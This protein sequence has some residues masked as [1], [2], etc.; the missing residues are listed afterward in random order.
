MA[1]RKDLPKTEARTGIVTK[2]AAV[3]K[4]FGVKP[5][6]ARGW[7][8]DG[9]PGTPGEYDLAEIEVWKRGRTRDPER[10]AG[11]FTAAA[12]S[13]DLDINDLYNKGM[14]A[15]AE[16]KIAKARIAKAS[17]EKKER[18]NRVASGQVA[19]RDEVERLFSET[20]GRLRDELGRVPLDMQASFPAK[21]RRELTEALTAR[22]NMA[23]TNFAAWGKAIG[24]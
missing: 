12:G 20:L 7:V 14:I 16:E 19:D 17:A 2:L 5:Q 4:A 24:G 6:T 13:A 1:K 15:T 23:L 22:I 3:A 18:E 8:S 21:V 11:E 9:M 10:M